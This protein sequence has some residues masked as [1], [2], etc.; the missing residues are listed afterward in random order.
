MWP[1][2]AINSN[3]SDS[4]VLPTTT[5]LRPP[6]STWNHL[7]SL[8]SQF[9]SHYFKKTTM[10]KSADGSGASLTPSHGRVKGS[11][12]AAWTLLFLLLGGSPATLVMADETAASP[13][14]SAIPQCGLYMAVSSTSTADEPKWGLFAG[15]TIEKG[16]RVGYGEVAIQT[17]H[18]LANQLSPADEQDNPTPNFLADVVDFFEQYIWVPHNSGGQ[19]E[20]AD[21]GRIVTAI[22]GVGVLGGYNPKMTNADW[23]QSRA[24]HRPNWGEHATLTH[25]GRGASSQYHESS[26]SAL[27]TIPAGMEIFINYGENWEPDGDAEEE[28]SAEIT[29]EDHQ[30][31][32]ETI[33]KM[34]AFFE[35]HGG[36]LDQESK[37]E[38][39]LFLIQDVLLAA[40]GRRKGKKISA[41]M[42]ETPDGLAE[43]KA[44]GGSLKLA[45][46]ESLRALP[47]L[48]K[49]G[50]CMDHIQ[51]GPSTIPH[52]GRGA[53]ATRALPA[54]SII[55][56]LPLV[57][58]VKGEIL[59]M[60]PLESHMDDDKEEYFIR[61]QDA[62]PNGSQL[63]FNYCLGHPESKMLF[64]PAGASTSFIN[65]SPTPNAKLVWSEHPNHHQH[66]FDLKPE[67]L[68]E[69]G[70]EH[71]GL[72][73][74]VVAL[75]DIA[76]GEEVTIDYG[77]EWAAAWDEHVQKWEAAVKEGTIASV[78]PT[79]AVDYNNQFVNKPFPLSADEYPE[80]LML[81]C[82]LLVTKPKEEPPINEAGQKIRHWVKTDRTLTSG[83]LFDCNLVDMEEVSAPDGA[84]SWNYTIQW[85]GKSE[86]TLVKHVPHEALVFMDRPGTSDQ[87][88]A[89]SFRHY[90]GIPDEIFPQGPW[91]NIQDDDS[92]QDDEENEGEEEQEGGFVDEE[93]E[94]DE[95][96]EDEAEE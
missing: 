71:I 95:D 24:Y 48:A 4:T 46:P 1:K 29:K 75:K 60:Y 63:L 35:K 7:C 70:N 59:N 3:R 53:L 11:R 64:F 9:S 26:L 77:P 69:E 32:D 88:V 38:I 36:E 66:W 78:W 82:F 72:L 79:R 89:Q 94:E 6:L 17:F 39:Y 81:K 37:Q 55:A 50:R 67:T 5:H 65:H 30:K 44:Q 68:M 18:M 84:T 14:E 41:M 10:A 92:I 28:E 83:N 49:H 42:P 34:I 31:I 22:P 51:P 20:L 54:G 76:P 13:E 23:N 96:E 45:S 15:E 58:I 87:H 12:I 93:D 80:N 85:Q 16:A 57:Q 86:T 25:P 91:R 74:E 62:E 19:Y 43:I 47:W 2:V 21:S 90:I 40:A 33:D 56:P 52:A 61:K 27:E 8:H 73:M